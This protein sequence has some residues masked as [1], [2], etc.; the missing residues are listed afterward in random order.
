MTGRESEIAFV[1]VGRPGAIGSRKQEIL[2]NYDKLYGRGNWRLP[3]DVNG[4]SV[5]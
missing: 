5:E 2:S 1:R 3:F 4:H